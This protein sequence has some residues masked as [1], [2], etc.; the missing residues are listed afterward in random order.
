[1]LTM[2]LFVLIRKRDLTAARVPF[3][4]DS[5]NLR[6]TKCEAFAAKRTEPS[7]AQHSRPRKTY[8]K[9]AEL[10]LTGY[11]NSSRRARWRE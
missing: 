11:E 8:C 9:K 5:G 3:V 10:T 4:A 1:M 7:C 2:G 6:K